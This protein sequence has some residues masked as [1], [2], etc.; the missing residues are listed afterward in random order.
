M[1]KSF[2]IVL[3]FLAG[4]VLQ[5][6]SAQNPVSPVK[7]HGALYVSGNKIL[8]QHGIQPQ[9]RGISL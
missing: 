7:N 3:I 4:S 9:L 2:F 5:I 1:K 6:S 8:D